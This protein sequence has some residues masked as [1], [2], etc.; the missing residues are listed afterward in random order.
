MT[1]QLPEIRDADA[2]IDMLFSSA[3]RV[4]GRG[5]DLSALRSRTIRKLHRIAERADRELS[6]YVVNFP[7]L[8]Q[9]S[10]EYDMADILSSAQKVKKSLASVQGCRNAIVTVANRAARGVA[11]A[12]GAEEIH[13]LRDEAYGRIASLL[14]GINPQLQF[15]RKAAVSLREVPDAAGGIVIA[16]FPNVGKSMLMSRITN[17]RTRVAPYPF[18]TRTVVPGKLR[19]GSSIVFDLPGITREGTVSRNAYERK[20]MAALRHLCK[21]L[22]YIADPTES[23]GYSLDEQ[24]KLYEEIRAEVSP[25]PSML[26]YSKADIRR[27]PGALSVSSLTGEGVAE[28]IELMNRSIAASYQNQ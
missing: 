6:S 4:Q 28:L 18:T 11:K 12:S 21:L 22:L 17:A 20:T 24:L 1:R 25:A 23:C 15:I 14:K 16:G 2:I 27:V 10:F 9:G 13:K 3:S 8:N 7:S 19:G 26:V 5:S